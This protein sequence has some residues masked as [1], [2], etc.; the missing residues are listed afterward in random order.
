MPE[1][2]ASEEFVDMTREIRYGEPSIQKV[3]TD[4]PGKL[5]R[6]CQKEF[7]RCVSR[8]YIDTAD[9]EAAPVGWVFQK[10]VEYDDCNKTYLRETWVTLFQGPKG[11]HRRTDRRE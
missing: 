10:R 8:V 9:E 6:Y 11:P 4:D 3:F 7:G 1:L 2:W 5:F